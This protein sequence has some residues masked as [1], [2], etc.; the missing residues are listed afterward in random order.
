[1]NGAGRYFYYLG[2]LSPS[3]T[4]NKLITALIYPIFLL[5]TRECL[6]RTE[7]EPK[8][9]PPIHHFHPSH[10]IIPSTKN[11]PLTKPISHKNLS[12]TKI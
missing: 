7:S 6:G 12:L 10:P 2:E 11:P 9:H 5:L 8:T 1:M 4:P 3:H